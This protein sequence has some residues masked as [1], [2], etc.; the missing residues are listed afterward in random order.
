M[1][2]QITTALLI[3]A[4]VITFAMAFQAV[5]PAVI[6]SSDALV[7]AGRL[8]SDRL[9]TDIRIIHASG[10]LDASG[11]WRDTNGDGDFDVFLSALNCYRYFNN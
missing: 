8:S 7:S 1:D 9:K 11:V 2:K 3:M 6:R 5:Y 4:A 10:E